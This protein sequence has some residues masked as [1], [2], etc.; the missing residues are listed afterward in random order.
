MPSSV[1]ITCFRPSFRSAPLHSG[2]TV[3]I[4]PSQTK[5]KI[6]LCPKV[7][8]FF[9]SLGACCGGASGALQDGTEKLLLPEWVFRRGD[10]RHQRVLFGVG[11]TVRQQVCRCFGDLYPVNVGLHFELLH[12]FPRLCDTRRV[13]G[14]HWTFL[15]ALVVLSV[16]VSLS[17]SSVFSFKC[18]TPRSFFA[19]AVTSSDALKSTRCAFAKEAEAEGCQ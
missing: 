12:Q 15:S 7:Q 5:A 10:R 11:F 16:P 2:G 3:T 17:S 19:L 8:K 4:A 14:R 6:F 9:P 1:H 18:P 13:V